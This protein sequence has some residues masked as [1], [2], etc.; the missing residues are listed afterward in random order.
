MR[1]WWFSLGLLGVYLVVFQA[2]VWLDRRWVVTTGI[3]GA[4]LFSG[5]EVAAARAAYFANS[6][7]MLFH[8]A[9]ILDLLLE[10]VWV[11]YHAGYGFYG[12]AAGFALVV[13]G[14]HAGAQRRRP[15]RVSNTT[16]PPAAR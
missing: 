13:G 10:A 6:W 9:M 16:A 15:S 3:G 12:C 8:A 7:D 14:Y 4:L 11:N 5:G 2:W 1:R